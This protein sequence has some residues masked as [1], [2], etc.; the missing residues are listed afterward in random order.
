MNN[1][2]FNQFNVQ[3]TDSNPWYN[4]SKLSFQPFIQPCSSLSPLDTDCDVKSGASSN[5]KV[6]YD[7]SRGFLGG[8]CLFLQNSRKKGN[9]MNPQTSTPM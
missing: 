3:I 5:A 1:D 7:T 4:I 6:I 9:F 2:F 8:G